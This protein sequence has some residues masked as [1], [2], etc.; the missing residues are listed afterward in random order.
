MTETRGTETRGQ[1]DARALSL[2][3][4]EE[5]GRSLAV[6]RPAETL[7]EQANDTLKS[8]VRG[9]YNHCSPGVTVLAIGFS[10]LATGFVLCTPLSA[11]SLLLLP[12]ALPFSL[13]GSGFGAD[14]KNFF[15]M[16]QARL[17]DLEADLKQDI[18]AAQEKA[19]GE[20]Q[21]LLVRLA[22]DRL[23]K[24]L[25][26]DREVL[27]YLAALPPGKLDSASDALAVTV[28]QARKMLAWQ[29]GKGGQTAAPLTFAS[30]SREMEL[31]LNPRNPR[32][33]SILRERLERADEP[34]DEDL[35]P[36]DFPAPDLSA[37]ERLRQD[38]DLNS[39]NVGT[40][41]LLAHTVTWPFQA[42][43]SLR[44][45][46]R[47]REMEIPAIPPV[48]VPALSPA[49]DFAA[50]LEE[51]ERSARTRLDLPA[52]QRDTGL[53]RLPPPGGQKPGFL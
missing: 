46:R 29:R 47:L 18:R 4:L 24:G 34:I 43:S 35:S 14:K 40:L 11:L 6:V 9:V 2:A 49:K 17:N 38:K 8:G 44:K 30:L 12:A 36:P 48:A 28:L 31:P 21:D 25:L 50:C 16:T 22:E 10:T 27:S 33:L 15:N 26:L 13:C 39:L 51:Y 45:M 37:I 32:H 53:R 5:E 20:K 3:S 7:L 42:I 52:L 1:R 41:N 19:F 23:G